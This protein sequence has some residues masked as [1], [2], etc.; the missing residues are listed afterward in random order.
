MKTPRAEITI[1]GRKVASAFDER[2]IALTV[3]DREGSVSDEVRFD[4]DDGNPFIAIPRKGDIV[5]VRLGYL[6][7][8][9]AWFGQYTV[10]DPEVRCLPYALSVSG[11]GA[12]MRDDLKTH[13]ERHWDDAPLSAVIGEI[14]A[15]HQL[16]PLVD[17]TLGGFVYH[18]IGQ[19]DE[20]DIHFLERLARRHG[21]VFSV[22]D[23][24]LIF[25]AKGSGRAPGG[26]ALTAIEASP[27][28]IVENSCVVRF[29]HRY[30]FRRAV[31]VTQDR[32]KADR[33]ESAA[34]SDEEGEA[35]YRLGEPFADEDE[36][37]AAAESQAAE[38]KRNT[39]T[40]SV[41]LWG[42][43]RIRAGAPFRYSGVRPEIDALRF[44]ITEA[45]HTLTK[46]G[47]TVALEAKLQAARPG[48]TTPSGAEAPTP[49]P[50]P[51]PNEPEARAP[52]PVQYRSFPE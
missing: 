49:T 51:R 2:L 44:V 30:K 28:T 11:K 12:S 35:D 42:D 29:A 47:Y 13:K 16:A 46:S 5:G 23:G 7:T 31:A 39:I 18:W 24:R 27:D 1:N 45:T 20:S 14:A 22:K 21:A 8:G 50:A 10:E 15:E 48:A 25:A 41:T 6:E 33:V 38:L 17:P 9:L 26:T 52:A 3:T 4:L 37:Q 40:T 43:P 19:Q 32:E 36:A 34:D